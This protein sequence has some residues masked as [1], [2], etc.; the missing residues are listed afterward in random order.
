IFGLEDHYRTH[1]AFYGGQLGLKGDMG[2]GPWFLGF[3]GTAALGAD[4]QLIR[5][6]GY[7]ITHTPGDR[8]VVPVG[9]LV[10]PNNTGRFADTVLDWMFDVGVNAGCHLTPH[11]RVFTGYTFLYWN[12]PIRSGGQIDLAM[13]AAQPGVPFKKEAF[14]AQGVNWG[15]E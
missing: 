11:C 7:Q 14:W 12:N 1:D 3:R 4:A 15:L 2:W 13:N 6:W 8:E 9:L 5:T 10:Q